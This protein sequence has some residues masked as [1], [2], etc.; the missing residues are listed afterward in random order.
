MGKII[1]IIIASMILLSCKKDQTALPCTAVPMT[2]ERSLFVGTW[3]WYSTTIEEWFDVGSPIYHDYTPI[4]E[5]F[6]Y[7]FTVSMDGKYKGYRND[8]LIHDFLLTGQLN[9]IFNGYPV[10]RLECKIDCTTNKI[11]FLHWV[12]NESN[13]S[14]YVLQYPLNFR[15]EATQRQSLS[16]YFVRE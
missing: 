2:G 8:T 12:W 15:D 6:E 1:A 13:D 3:H 7:Y 16:N 10:D 5:E 4:T 9:E 11:D 14:I